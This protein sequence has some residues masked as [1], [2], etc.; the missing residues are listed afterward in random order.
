MIM[1]T[2][3][4]LMA[5]TAA[6]ALPA[7]MRA[8]Q[9]ATPPNIVVMAKTIDDIV[10]AFDPAE[11]Y[12]FTNN[13]VCGNLY[14]KLLLP[15]R[16]DTS[17]LAGDAAQHWEVSGDGL[18]FTFH[19]KPDI[20]FSSGKPLTAEDA[21]FSLQRVVKL[22]KTPGFIITQFGFTPDNVDKLITAADP[23]T[24]TMKLP[25]VQAT[26]FVL[27][28]L[29]ATVGS[30]VE[31]AEVMA[32][33]VG[34]DLG[35]A[36]VKT[37]SAGAGPYTLVSWQAA[38]HIVLQASPHAEVKARIPRVILRHV[39]DPAAQLLLLQKGDVD[40]ARDLT[41]DQIKTIKS[42]ADYG[43][44]LKNQLTSMYM[45]MNASYG[46]LQK[47]EVR[48]AI[49]MAIDYGALSHDI[50][51]N[52]WAVWES[53]L[54]NG[55]PGAIGEQPFHKDP[56]GA[57][58]LLAKAGYPDGFSITLDHFSQ[59]PY[60]EIAQAIQ[61]DLGAAGIKVTLLPAVQKQVFSKNRARQHQLLLTTWFPDYL[62]PNS[63]AQAFCV[64]TDDSDASKLRTPAWRS[65]FF[66][67]ELTAEVQAAVTE[68]DTAKRA[69]LYGKVQRQFMQVATFAFILQNSEVATMRRGVS[70]LELGVLPDYTR[71]AAIVKG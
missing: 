6:G 15:D 65:H 47:V 46:P 31:K 19:L 7:M 17:K 64:S 34:G 16:A 56:Q 33:D 29:S 28:C 57:K 32:H 13:E 21:A 27:Y 1:L 53:F 59:S 60:A 61:A 12:E 48:Q 49:K 38:D 41:A 63:N 50:T 36:W 26:S 23:Q 20:L 52:L 58:A 35:N 67:K 18:T 40:I 10:G 24:L 14:R 69:A 8:G 54:P 5:S 66:D 44:M 2:R 71:Y 42:N 9:A 4:T 39:A 3:R 62:D 55:V 68:L 22:N 43:V 30:I 11:S 51:Q 70:G 37:H 25:Q 45:A